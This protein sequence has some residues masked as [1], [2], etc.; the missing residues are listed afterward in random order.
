M[1]RISPSRGTHIAARPRATSRPA[2]RPASSRPARAGRSSPCP[3]TAAPWSAP[4]TTTSTA[5]SPIPRPGGDDIAYL[6]EAVNAFFATSLSRLRPGRR[7]RRGAAAD[8][9]RRPAEVGRHL[10]A[11][12]ALRDLLGDADDHRRQADHLAADG[13]ADRRSPGR[14]GGPRGA[15]PTAEIPLGMEAWPED[16]EATAGGGGGVGRPARL[17]LR[18]RRPQRARPGRRAPAA[19]GADRRGPPRPAGRGRRSP[20]GI[21]QAR[22]RRRRDPPPHPARPARCP[23]LRGAD[24]VRPVAEAMGAELGWSESRIASEAEAWPRVAAEEGI[25]PASG[26]PG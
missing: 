21:E 4:P 12:R 3:G 1:P 19:G 6:L 24:S 26:A 14:A 17:P 18:A 25:D 2:R 13:E 11:G 22:E 8:L 16:L 15:L 23:Q 9:D 5:T 20:P 10:A 7:L